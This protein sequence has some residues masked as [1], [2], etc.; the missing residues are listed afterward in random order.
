MGLVVVVGE[1]VTVK[2]NHTSYELKHLRIFLEYKKNLH[3][4]T[5]FSL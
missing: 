1:G 3:V 5:Y 4:C 2:K